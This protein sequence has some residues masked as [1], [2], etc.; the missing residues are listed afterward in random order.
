MNLQAM[1]ELLRVLQGVQADRSPFDMTVWGRQLL[2]D[3]TTVEGRK[4]CG[5]AA[6]AAGWAMRD[7]WF[8][9]RGLLPA[10]PAQTEGGYNDE[11][12]NPNVPSFDG[13]YGQLALSW[14]FGLTVDQT[15]ELF[16]DYGAGLEDRINLVKQMIEE[17]KL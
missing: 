7:P 6:C 8:R 13:T 2:P 9:E 4:S 17:E 11:D 10:G 12:Y 3:G 1:T 5:T 15:Q 14:F 16:F